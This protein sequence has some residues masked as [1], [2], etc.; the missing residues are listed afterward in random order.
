MSDLKKLFGG[1][2]RQSRKLKGWTQ[3]QLADAADLSLDMIGRMERG[4]AAP[5]FE[6]IEALANVLGV[7]PAVPLGSPRPAKGESS[8]RYRL[9]RSI[10]RMLSNANDADLR[11]VERVIAAF[12]K[13]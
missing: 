5:S 3:A 11:R 4:Q 8:E 1:S 2:L 6:T 13:N 9:L 12:L 10:D 7:V